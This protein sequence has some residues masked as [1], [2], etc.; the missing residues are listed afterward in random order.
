MESSDFGTRAKK[1]MQSYQVVRIHRDLWYTYG[2]LAAQAIFG[3]GSVKDNPQAILVR[4]SE[5][6]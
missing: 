4:G 2:R 6:S 3:F 5:N 1:N